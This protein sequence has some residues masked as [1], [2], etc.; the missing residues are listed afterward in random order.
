MPDHTTHERL[1]S[2]ERLRDQALHAGSKAAEERQRERGKLLARERLELLLDP[3]SFVELDTFVQHRNPDLGPEESRPLGDG[4]VTGHGTIEGR[5]VFV[6]SQDFTVFGGSLGEA[7]A[8]KICKVMDMALRY[9]CPVIGINDSGG[10]RIQEG[11]VSLAGYADIFTR[12][13]HASGVV[14]QISLIMG[15][16]A[17]GA[18]YSPAITDFVLMTEG[19]SHM[20]ITG[21]EVV[22]TVTGEEVTFEELGGA[23]THA[24]RSGVAHLTAPDEKSLLSD[25]RYLLSFLP[26]SSSE[27]PPWEPP[28]DPPD[29]E[30]AELDAV[31]P[32]EATKPYD[33]HDV[34]RRVVDD[35]EFLEVQPLF[36][37]NI[38]CGMARLGGYPVGV[39]AN[40]PRALAGV[41]D[42][43]SSVK[44]A[45]FV[46]TCDAFG[47]P[48][49]TFVD[50]PGFLPGTDQEWGGIIRHGAKL[51]Y[52][53]C[54]ASVPKLAVITRKAYGGA[55][56]VMSSKHVGA[57]FNFAWP[58][59]E[60]AV[61]GPDG[62]VNIVYRR[63]LETADDPVQRRAELVEEY[64]ERFANPFTAASR[65]YV[66][67]VIAPR[68]TRRALITALEACRSKRV[69]P[70]H[71]KHGNIPL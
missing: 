8:E 18:V 63:E 27:P 32:D 43:S 20:F 42:I 15:P 9:G 34:I 22:K 54:E 31:V 51:L 67:D 68:H 29:R 25:C 71:R 3:G 2:V 38:I 62:A 26:Q 46:R 58:T 66:D 45:R 35:G 11:V 41:L 28:T 53:Y 61:M 47:L 49:V 64:R 14:P 5:R 55:Y 59:A 48:L 21:P 1:E 33:M 23:A 65:G 13:V 60:V 37:E 24:R 56:D 17:G 30:D 40:Q 16:C 70:P 7:F 36:A 6:F 69:D 57:D 52:A 39:V 12:N 19:T 4:V 44:A 50:V 10:A